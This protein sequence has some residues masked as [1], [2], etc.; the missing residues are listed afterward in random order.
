MTM[1]RVKVEVWSDFVCP[2]CLIA[3]HPLRQAVQMVQANGVQVDVE[4]MPFELRPHPT[5]TLRPEDPYLQTVWPQS[6][7]P[8]ARR[9]GVALKLPSVSPQPHSALAWQGY[10]HAKAHGLGA[11]Y[12]QAV[13]HAFFQHD[14]DIGRTEVLAALAAGIGLDAT[15]FTAALQ[16]GRYREAHAQALARAQAEGVNSVPAF[17]IGTRRLAG[18]QEAQVL[19]A[20]LQAA[21]QD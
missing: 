7:Y 11:A 21:A 13:L 3:E 16:D 4:W 10:Q 18:V 9:F 12:N 17:R 14:L 1:K 2:F 19:A 15:A 6:V 8:V 20:A 5:P